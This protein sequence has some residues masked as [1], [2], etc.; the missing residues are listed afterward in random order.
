MRIIKDIIKL[1]E[2]EELGLWLKFA[3]F[4]GWVAIAVFILSLVY[5]KVFGL[6]A[7]F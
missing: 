7:A 5:F 3:D 1:E 6:P 4:I 2:D